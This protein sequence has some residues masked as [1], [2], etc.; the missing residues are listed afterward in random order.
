ME[1]CAKGPLVAR[2]IVCRGDI[3]ARDRHEIWDDG[4]YCERHS[5]PILRERARE[6]ARLLQKQAT[7]QSKG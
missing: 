2:C 6:Y 3:H 1:G 7:T 4:Y 5:L